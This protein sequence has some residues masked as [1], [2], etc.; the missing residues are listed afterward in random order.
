MLAV[1]T[2]H[3]HERCH[4]H[5][6]L[7]SPWMASNTGIRVEVCLNILQVYPYLL[8]DAATVIPVP[9]TRWLRKS[10]KER[11]ELL[12]NWQNLLPSEVKLRLPD[13]LNQ[14]AFRT[15]VE[16]MQGRYRSIGMLFESLGAPG[17]SASAVFEASALLIQ[18]QAV[19][20]L[21]GPTACNLFF[22]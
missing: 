18:T 4:F 15:L 10:Q 7:L 16:H 2:A 12:K 20:D 17:L 19:H 3:E 9:L 1:A 14:R 22:K 11:S 8:N 13:F 6:W 21:F 5:D